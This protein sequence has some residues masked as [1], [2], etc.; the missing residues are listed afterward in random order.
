MFTGSILYLQA[1]RLNR[2]LHF[3]NTRH[4]SLNY[5]YGVTE[6]TSTSFL[7]I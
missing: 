7:K 2:V 1:F 4:I 5:Q 6:K 3:Q